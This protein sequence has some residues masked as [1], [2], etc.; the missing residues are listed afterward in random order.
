MKQLNNIKLMSK[1][2]MAKVAGAEPGWIYHYRAKNGFS[3]YYGHSAVARDNL[4]R[5]ITVGRFRTRREA[6]EAIRKF[7]LEYLSKAVQVPDDLDTD[8]AIQTDD[9]TETKP[10]IIKIGKRV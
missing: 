2:E 8:V 3:C 5:W 7:D 10:H 9:F 1:E 4:G 6:E